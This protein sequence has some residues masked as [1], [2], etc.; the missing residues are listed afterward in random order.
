MA[1]QYNAMGNS[2]HR[3]IAV[4]LCRRAVEI[5]PGYARAWALLA[6]C[7]ANGRMVNTG[8]GDT[9]WSAAE[10]ALALEPNLAEA[11]AAKGRILGDAGQYDDAMQEHAIA[12]ELDPGGYE[13][14]AA[15]ARCMISTRDLK[16]ATVCLERAAVAIEAD[17]W[18][19]GMA[20]QCYEGL[21]DLEGMKSAAR[22]ALERV[23][24][25]IVAEPDHA[26]A[27]GWGVSALIALREVDRAKEWIERAMLLEPDNIN[28]RYNLGCNMATLGE[29]ARAIELL[30]PVFESAQ[31]QNVIWARVDNSLDPIRDD[32]RYKAMIERAEA[33]L[34]IG[35]G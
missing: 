31:P 15:A 16:Q 34:G 2:R 33:R 5:D 14:N 8:S 35:P 6:I 32:P 21:G 20:I 29:A 3:D 23:E 26:L 1:R 18:A 24:K 12:L 19:L 30:E 17:F 22:R 27:I 9:G 25:V 4:R 13:V 28:L 10:R 11:H 7:L